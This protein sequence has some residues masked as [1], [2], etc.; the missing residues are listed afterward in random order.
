MKLNGVFK[1]IQIKNMRLSPSLGMELCPAM[2]DFQL[3]AI[4]K[5]TEI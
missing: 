1:R 2:Q 5:L 3:S 4:S